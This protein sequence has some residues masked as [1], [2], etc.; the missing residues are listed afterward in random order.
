[1]AIYAVHPQITI[2]PLKSD[3][4]LNFYD[5]EHINN[6]IHGGLVSGQFSNTLNPK[7]NLKIDSNLHM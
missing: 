6:A 3:D 5:L 2:F 7:C 4:R 1:M